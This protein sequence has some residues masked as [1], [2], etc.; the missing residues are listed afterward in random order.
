MAFNDASITIN[1]NTAL[2]QPLKYCPKVAIN[3]LEQT[4]QKLSLARYP[5]EQDDFG[6]D[7]WSQGAKVDEVARLAEY[8]CNEYDW[9]S[10]EVSS[11][12]HESSTKD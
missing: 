5:E 8:W 3:F 2:N 10:R 6:P 1:D 12:Y 7:N 9:S 11:V 4:R